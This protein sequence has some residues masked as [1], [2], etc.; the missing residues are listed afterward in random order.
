MQLLVYTNI[1]RIIIE[2]IPKK[3]N[4]IVVYRPM[5]KPEI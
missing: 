1:K 5:P 4:I 2:G 3:V